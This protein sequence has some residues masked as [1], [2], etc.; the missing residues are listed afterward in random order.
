MTRLLHAAR[1]VG[2]AT[3]SAAD[4][5]GWLSRARDGFCATTTFEPEADCRFDRMGAWPLPA[6]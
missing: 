2:V 1:A 6:R 3:V 5:N 4:A